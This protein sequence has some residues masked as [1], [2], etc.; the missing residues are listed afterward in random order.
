M[1]QSHCFLVYLATTGL[2]FGFSSGG[3]SFLLDNLEKCRRIC[4]SYQQVLDLLS[5]TNNK[6]AVQLAEH[7]TVWRMV[8]DSTALFNSTSIVKN[9]ELSKLI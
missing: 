7:L 2:C 4:S 6:D 9:L 8:L 3:R 1:E 5:F